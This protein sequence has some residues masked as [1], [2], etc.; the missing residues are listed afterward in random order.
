M[1]CDQAKL[2][3]STRR[4]LPMAQRAEL[5]A[6]LGSCRACAAARR[7]EDR[8]TRLLALLPDPH[9]AVPARVGLAVRTMAARPQRAAQLRRGLALAA[10]L[11]AVALLAALLLNAASGGRLLGGVDALESAARPLV[12]AAPAPTAGAQASGELLYL[13]HQPGDSGSRVVAW[14]PVADRTLFSVPLGEP[15]TYFIDA[16]NERAPRVEV[17]LPPVDVVLSP[18]RSRMFVIEYGSRDDA[19]VAY[20][21][22]GGDELWRTTLDRLTR[23]LSPGEGPS[24]GISPAGDYLW[25]LTPSETIPI[26]DLRPA[27]S[28]KMRDPALVMFDTSSGEQLGA[29][30]DLPPWATNLV[31]VDRKS[32]VILGGEW[33]TY[34]ADLERG[35]TSRAL[36]EYT[37]AGILLPNKRTLYALTADLTVLE[38]DLRANGLDVT[39]EADLVPRGAFFFDHAAFAPDGQTLV[40]GRSDFAPQRGTTSEVRIFGAG[41]WRALFEPL[42]YDRP[43]VDLAVSGDGERVYIVLGPGRTNGAPLGAVPPSRA[44]LLTLHTGSGAITTQPLDGAIVGIVAGR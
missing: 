13:V 32:G 17:R 15:T 5:D 34:R 26:G 20:D 11:G 42:R 33:G 28:N 27:N 21:A 31:S 39:A 40:V 8:T 38:L 29:P 36:R 35:L 7:E 1:R 10:S 41:P 44:A 6:H 22:R 30:V 14:D 12:T 18:D 43:L 4:D 25:M 37:V 9:A 24:L 23:Y 16:P 2:L 3:L 19:L